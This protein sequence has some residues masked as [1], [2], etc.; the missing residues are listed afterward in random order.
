M[1][2]IMQNDIWQF[3][4]LQWQFNDPEMQP[5]KKSECGDPLSDDSSHIALFAQNVDTVPCMARDAVWGV[6]IYSPITNLSSPPSA[7][8]EID[9][10][11]DFIYLFCKF[12][13]SHSVPI[14]FLFPFMCCNCTPSVFMMAWMDWVNL[15]V[16]TYGPEMHSEIHAALVH[17]DHLE[18]CR[19]NFLLFRVHQK[20]HSVL[21]LGTPLRAAFGMRPE[22]TLPLRT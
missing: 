14:Q 11:I 4:I 10:F 12:I 6:G 3:L 21:W 2:G 13:S 20:Q 16:I 7:T 8:P 5:N 19:S 17:F 18:S 1:N 22:H 15:P 9:S